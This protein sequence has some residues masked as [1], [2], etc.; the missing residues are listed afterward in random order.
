MRVM[1]PGKHMGCPTVVRMRVK[2]ALTH[3]SKPTSAS[4][5]SL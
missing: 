1:E 5:V 3:S 4:Q 2:V